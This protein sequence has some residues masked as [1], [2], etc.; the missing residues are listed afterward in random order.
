[1]VVAKDLMDSELITIEVPN[2]RSIVLELMEK[3]GIRAIPVVKKG[4]K[5][6]VGIVSMKDLL[7]NPSEGDL[8]MLMRRDLITVSPNSSLNQIK[9]LILK[10]KIRRFPVVEESNNEVLGMLSVRN[11]ISKAISVMK[12]KDPIKNYIIRNFTT[13]WEDT[14]L[15][16]IPHIMKLANVSIIP[17]ID[18]EGKLTGMISNEEM[19]KNGEIISENSKSTSGTEEHDWSWDVTSTQLITYRKLKLPEVPVKEIMVKK[20]ITTVENFSIP[21]CAKKMKKHNINQMPVLDANNKL[22]GIITDV[23]LIKV[24]K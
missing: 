24:L 12:I 10:H 13:V 20:L 23:A 14:P 2:K 15:P 8:G 5:T 7:K 17:V 22:L 9:K 1:M 19:V 18:R 11:I 16:V 6:L 3:K 4:T 21:D